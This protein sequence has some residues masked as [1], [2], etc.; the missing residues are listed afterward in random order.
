MLKKKKGE[1]G[2]GTL[3]IFIA[4]ILVAAIAAGVLI[5]TATSLQS[6]ALLTGER[7]KEQVSTGLMATMLYAENAT[8]DHQVDEFYQKTKLVPGS[9]ALKFDEMTIMFVT[10]DQKVN[11]EY[12]SGS[13]TKSASSGFYTNTTAGIAYYTVEY[14]EQGENYQAGYLQRGDLVKIC[15]QAP[16]EISEDETISI[17]LVPKVGNPLTIETATPNVMTD[18]KVILYP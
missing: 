6:K 13:C 4:M 17:S 15:Y 12:R 5:R 9:G 1:M 16:R 11:L 14:L 8:S 7:S 3:I 18:E 10:K 2:I